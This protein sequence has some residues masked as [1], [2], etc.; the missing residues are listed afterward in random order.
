MGCIDAALALAKANCLC[1][2]LNT[3]L[4]LGVVAMCSL[5]KMWGYSIPM[6]IKLSAMIS[7]SVDFMRN[8]FTICWYLIVVGSL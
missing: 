1:R 5:N 3:R 4:V 6:L 7:A 8:I 2:T